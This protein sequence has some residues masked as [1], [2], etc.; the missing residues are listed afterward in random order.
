M[1]HV[2]RDAEDLLF[3]L[4]DRPPGGGPFVAGRA[5]PWDTSPRGRRR[6][7]VTRG[8]V[9]LADDPAASRGRSDGDGLAG[10]DRRSISPDR[11]RRTAFGARARD[12]RD[13]GDR[14]RGRAGLGLRG[15]PRP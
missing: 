2:K 1:L 8:T 9:R 3:W 6:S 4:D 10:V 14:S 5:G 15:G 13:G 12:H 7:T 11:D